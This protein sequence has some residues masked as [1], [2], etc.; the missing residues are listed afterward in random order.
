MS[1]P[2]ATRCPACQT[3]FR[4]VRD[5]LRVSGGW[6][7]CG[8]CAEVFNAAEALLNLDTG[9]PWTPQDQAQAEAEAVAYAPAP[10][11]ALARVPPR[12]GPA[13][14]TPQNHDPATTPP[15]AAG[16]Q[17]AGDSGSA[18]ESARRRDADTQP[19]ADPAAAFGTDR[20]TGRTPDH[21]TDRIAGRIAGRMPDRMP[22]RIPD[23]ATDPA[24]DPTT[25][26]DVVAAAAFV[27][28]FGAGTQ[29]GGPILPPGTRPGSRIEPSALQ[30]IAA[31]PGIEAEAKAESE[32][33]EPD[34]GDLAASGPPMARATA[35]NRPQRQPAPQ[36]EASLADARAEALPS[37]VK[38]AERAERWRK[39]KVRTALLLCAA[40]FALL[41]AAQVAFSY[42]DLLAA[43]VP[44]SEPWLQA[45]CAL[46]GCTVGP[47]LAINSLVVES[48]GLLRLERS[49][50]YRLQVALRNRAGIP[51]AIPA[52]DVTLT[53]TQGEIITRKVLM[54][55]DLGST[56]TR[57]EAGQMATLQAVLLNTAQSTDPT[58]EAIA[59]YTV[60]LFYP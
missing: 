58:A 2:L 4:V 15:A 60:E 44:A 42:R 18:F 13:A 12:A 33:L 45:G 1:N 53:D 46:L 31:S 27:A 57:L 40:L 48:S 32:T 14:A 52:I 30:D 34:A 56:I 47:A 38:A 20:T 16:V 19:G 29:P 49:N 54:P 50:R 22:D 39:P 28:R 25:D 59:G 43:R 5:Q 37:F 17:A 23:R 36:F 51:V 41:L 3:V 21:T 10:A 7:R 6:V 11:P 35:A 26:P 9:L 55:A 8:R 24:I